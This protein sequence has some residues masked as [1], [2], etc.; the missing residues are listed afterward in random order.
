MNDLETIKAQE[1][2]IREGLVKN[3]DLVAQLIDLQMEYD[4]LQKAYHGLLNGCGPDPV[5]FDAEDEQERTRYDREDE[6]EAPV[7]P[8]IPPQEW[9][10]G[11][12]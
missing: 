1:I 7:D 4:Q 6:A 2:A 8:L 9:K 11:P 10:G 3:A 12:S 5:A